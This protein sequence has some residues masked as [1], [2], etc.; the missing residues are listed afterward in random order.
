MSLVRAMQ[1]WR[2]TALALAAIYAVAALL[3]M[4]A[5]FDSLRDTVLWVAFLG[6]GA[7]LIVLGTYVFANSPWVGAVLVS[8]GAAA[9]GF[10]LFWTILVP[11]VGAIVVAL[12]ISIARQLSSSTA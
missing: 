12:S 10:P 1:I 11:I 8:V 2:I 5:E 6:G 4:L 9:G 3:G 7:L